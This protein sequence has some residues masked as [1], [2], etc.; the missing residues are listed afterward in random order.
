[1]LIFW[2][3]S[4]IKELYRQLSGLTPRN[5]GLLVELDDGLPVDEV[6]VVQILEGEHDLRSVEPT[7]RLTK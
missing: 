1:M 2:F 5:E 3:F 7:V 4:G 6:Q